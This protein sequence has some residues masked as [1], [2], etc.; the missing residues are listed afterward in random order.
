MALFSSPQDKLIHRI[1]GFL[2]KQ[3]ELEYELEEQ[4]KNAARSMV[5]NI[6]G[7][8]KVIGGITFYHALLKGIEMKGLRELCNNLCSKP[9]TAAILVSDSLKGKGYWIAGCHP[10]SNFDFDTVKDSLL[11]YIGG[12]GGGKPPQWQGGWNPG[13]AGDIE[14]RELLKIFSGG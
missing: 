6:K 12:K 5:D 14:S 4:K 11:K 7:E 1:E 9:D 10:E 3:K 8:G 2:E 13:E